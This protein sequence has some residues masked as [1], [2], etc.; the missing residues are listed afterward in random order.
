MIE[1]KD[2]NSFI[3]D[4]KNQKNKE[5]QQEQDYLNH[6][7]FNK[8]SDYKI[9][10]DSLNELLFLDSLPPILIGK[11]FRF[12]DAIFRSIS[13][14]L[15]SIDILLR[16]KHIN[17]AISLI[18][19]YYDAS[20]ISIYLCLVLLDRDS[21]DPTHNIN[22]IINYVIN[23]EKLPEYRIINEYCKKHNFIKPIFDLLEKKV[24][25]KEIRK[26]CNNSSHYNGFVEFEFNIS[27]ILYDRKSHLDFCLKAIKFLFIQ[28]ISCV[29]MINPTFM[30]SSDLSDCAWIGESSHEGCQYWVA[31]FICDMF[32]KEFKPEFIELY[33]VIKNNC[34]MEI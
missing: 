7:L 17:D 25:Y 20:I 12:H 9:F 22:N 26:I 18:R 30:R 31:P 1:E 15:E 19:K 14:T 8:I 32:D 11:T 13:I 3:K 6:E 27:S 23:K 5:N 2:F 28:H 33:N 29:F 24:N 4:M 10:Y 34:S 16:K 21:Q